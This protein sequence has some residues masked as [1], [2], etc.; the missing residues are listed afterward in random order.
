MLKQTTVAPCWRA[1]GLK[2]RTRAWLATALLPS[3]VLT[4]CGVRLS[5][6]TP[7]LPAPPA[8]LMEPVPTGSAYLESVSLELKALDDDLARWEEMLRDS[9][10]R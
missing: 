9:L 8:E 4:G 1:N 5:K 6:G 2:Q 10:T 3:L 7:R